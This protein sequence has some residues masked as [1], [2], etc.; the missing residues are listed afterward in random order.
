MQ[1]QIQI[2]RWDNKKKF[3]MLASTPEEK[4]KWIA[5]LTKI[6]DEF[7]SKEQNSPTNKV[8]SCR[9]E[10]IFSGVYP[11]DYELICCLLLYHIRYKR[12]SS[13]FIQFKIQVIQ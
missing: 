12:N 6:I 1:N 5:D 8:T 3:L 7:L 10:I 9:F 2:V 4:K 13:L 11:K